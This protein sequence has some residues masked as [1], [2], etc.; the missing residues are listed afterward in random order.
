MKPPDRRLGHADQQ[1]VIAADELQRKAAAGTIT[2]AELLRLGLLQLEPGHDGF[3][4]AETMKQAITRDPGADVAR[5]W[6]AYLYV[7][8]LMDEMAL[9]EAVRVADE[10]SPADQPLKA[11]ALWLKGAA[12]RALNDVKESIAALEHSVRLEPEWIANRL[13][14]A[15][16]YRDDKRP[17]K[18][19]AEF[20]TA[21]ANFE[22]SREMPPEDDLFERLITGRGGSDQTA[23]TIH[24]A[25]ERA[26]GRPA[27]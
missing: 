22:N 4:A 25:I 13:A 26:R 5:V 16:A 18:S 27:R 15:T 19:I 7:Y 20:K 2:N 17:E 9:R 12:L 21:L 3:A 14:L 10:V 6:L 1:D 23:R 8:E 11:A 24:E